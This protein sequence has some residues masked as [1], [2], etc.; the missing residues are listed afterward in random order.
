MKTICVIIL[1]AFSF[2]TVNAQS[3]QWA[4]Q[5]SG[6]SDDHVKGM[7]VDDF[8]NSFIT[9]IF[10]DS[11]SF[12]ATTLISTGGLTIFLAK[13]DMNGILLWAKIAARDSAI[14][15]NSIS[16]DKQGNISIVGHF[17]Q[18]AIF[19]NS[20]TTTLNSNGSFD[21]FVARYDTGGNLLWAKSA[22]TIGYDYGSGVSTDGNGNT[23]I[24]GE[25]HITAY[26]F[27]SSKIFISKYDSLGNNVWTKLSLDN[28]STDLGGGIQTDSNG[29][30]YITGQFFQTLKFDSSIV[31]TSGNP[32]S[33]I[34][35][36]K[37]NN[38]GQNIWLQKAGAGAGYCGGT[39]IDIDK[40]GNSF[41]IGFFH[42]TILFDS[43]SISGSFG[44][45]LEVFITK[46]DSSGNF[47]WATK[48][49]GKGT[50]KSISITNNGDCYVSGDFIDTLVV[51]ST[52]ITSTAATAI[53]LI[54]V[55]ASGNFNWAK[56]SGGIY[57]S[58]LGGMKATPNGI[59][60]AGRYLNS[61]VFTNQIILNATNNSYDIFTAKLNLAT[62]VQE[63]N[64][65]KSI[66]IFPNPA[67]SSIFVEGIS[68]LLLIK[69]YN[70]FGQLLNSTQAGNPILSIN[71][72]HY[73]SGVYFL[74]VND[75][76]FK[77]TFKF[78]KAAN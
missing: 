59:Y 77:K 47:V 38:N 35:I 41:I 46:C 2:S 39:S 27:S 43:I 66:H 40:N 19:G 15:L 52:T 22:G 60:V 62:G 21:V 14:I 63:N 12:D 48:T 44:N 9:G 51:G 34:Y 8:G 7:D 50:G 11:I 13:Y 17:Y 32:E 54:S 42:G 45:G 33:N 3:W 73:N 67:Y 68:K 28:I 24:T 4:K 64:F 20:T 18:S 76:A 72:S 31:L 16:V 61:L 5:A 53:F 56:K 6:I 70:S 10:R 58:S 37:F 74:E 1:F 69:I 26:Q 25:Y 71:I 29:T 75:G 23:F 78:I 36:A 65:A 57:N 30:S 55:D 49:H